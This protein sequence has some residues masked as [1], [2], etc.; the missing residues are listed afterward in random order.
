MGR[1]VSTGGPR[2]LG[3]AN[4]CK[5]SEDDIIRGHF[6]SPSLGCFGHDSRKD[7]FFQVG[8]H[9]KKQ[10]QLKVLLQKKL[11]GGVGSRLFK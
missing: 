3:P 1:N 10:P 6:F 7:I 8:S 5:H 11:E 2:L 9:D 4:K